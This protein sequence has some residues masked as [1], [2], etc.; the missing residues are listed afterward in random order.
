MPDRRAAPVPPYGA[1]IQQAIAQGDLAHMHVLR[2]EAE[3]L[4]A[5]VGDV[6]TAH[7][8]LKAEILRA[9]GVIGSQPVAAATK[10]APRPTAAMP[11]GPS[12]Q[13]AVASGEV[14][15]MQQVAAS[16]AEWLAEHGDLS[17]SVEMLRIE[18]AKLE[19]QRI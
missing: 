13:Q 9:G 14:V 16:T 3:A 18:I 1:A 5:K 12:I 19:A 11:Y 15:R 7:E 2:A 8:V 6:A 4:L 17:A 10:G